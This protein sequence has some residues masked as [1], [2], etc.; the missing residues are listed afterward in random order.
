MPNPEVLSGLRQPRTVRLEEARAAAANAPEST[1]VAIP[2]SA[3]GVNVYV[4]RFRGYLVELMNIAGY[5][6]QGRRVP[7]KRVAVQFSEGI[8]RN[9]HHDPEMRT[10]IDR[11]LQRNKYF[12]KPGGTAH[13]WL[14]A[15]QNAMIEAARIKS[16]VDTLKGLP[17][18][19]VEQ[20]LAQGTAEDHALPPAAAPVR[21]IA[22]IAG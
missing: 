15:E 3:P 6:D 11:E 22:P 7:A 1:Q 20:Y 10:L 18:D 9:D 2:A 17:R 14:A 19:V 13:F 4:S 12:G 8:F 5:L 16:A 21:P